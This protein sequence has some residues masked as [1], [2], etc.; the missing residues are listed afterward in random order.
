MQ[1]SPEN[2]T[3]DD[4]QGFLAKVRR[5]FGG[6]DDPLRWSLP[7]FTFA[8]IAVRLHVFFLVFIVAQLLSS[9]SPNSLGPMYMALALAA[10]FGIVL[11]HEFGHC[12]A[13]R[14]AEGEAD[15]ILMWPL[16]GLAYCAPAN[17]P[18]SHLITVLGGPAVNV[19]L[20]PIF[21]VPLYLLT[22]DWHAALPNV[23]QLVALPAGTSLWLHALWWLNV[24][25]LILLLFNLLPMFPLDGGRIVQALLWMKTDYRRA[26][27]IA[28]TTGFAAAIVL[29]VLALA[30]N[31][32]MML[33]IA[34]FGGIVCYLEKR[35]L[36]FAQEELGFA[37]YDFSQGYS[38]L[39]EDEETPAD[40]RA[41]KAE[42]RRAR[43][44]AELDRILAKVS[45]EG[46]ERLT[47]KERRV[48]ERA[49]KRR[50]GE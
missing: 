18:R 47:R 23:F 27:G 48:L 40:K 36:Q 31:E 6:S 16:G 21:A 22:G 46:M 49:T 1:G 43:E 38:G 37:G 15:E 8:R 29:G 34:V 25:N 39:E 14:Y 19:V 10:L 50:Q 13:C 32:I 20:F 41:E 4:D 7:L 17:T 30:L 3:S 33:G 26:M 2:W 11:L 24:I 28:V 45:T 42:E 35:R 44:A 9:L 5:L 12:F